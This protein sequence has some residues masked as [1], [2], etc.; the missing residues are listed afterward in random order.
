MTS[1]Q[2]SNLLKHNN[3][4]QSDC[5]YVIV[6]LYLAFMLYR[7]SISITINIFL[8]YLCCFCSF[9]FGSYLV[10]EGTCAEVHDYYS[11]FGKSFYKQRKRNRTNQD[12]C[13]GASQCVKFNIQKSPSI[14]RQFLPSSVENDLQIFFCELCH[15][16]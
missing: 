1:Y 15:E 6:V 2:S 9:V 16:R 14:R 8:F 7:I 4:K 5:I 13:T 10:K 3:P 11:H 12:F